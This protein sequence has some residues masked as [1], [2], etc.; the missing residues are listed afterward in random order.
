MNEEEYNRKYKGRK[1]VTDG[2]TECIFGNFLNATKLSGVK[3]RFVVKFSFM[4]ESNAYNNDTTYETDVY[5]TDVIETALKQGG[6]I[7]K[8]KSIKLIK[9][10]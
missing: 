6:W 3:N 4:S 9:I 7:L 2:G 5:E 1:F 10:T 8:D